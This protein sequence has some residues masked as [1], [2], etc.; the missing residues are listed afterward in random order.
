MLET[1]KLLFIG[2]VIG[3]TNVIPGVSGGTMAVVFN[4]YDRFVDVLTFN[5]QKLKANW[6]FVVPVLIG[7]AGGILFF[8]KVITILFVKFPNQTNLFFTGLILGSIPMLYLAA[9]KKY[10]TETTPTNKQPVI[11]TV[12]FIILGLALLL[13]IAYIQKKLNLSK[14]V[15]LETLPPFTLKLA[16]QLFFGGAVGAVAMIIPGVSGSFLMLIMGVYPIII[17]GISSIVMPSTFL[18]ALII[19]LP[20]GVG[21]LLGLACGARAISWLLKKFPNQTYGIILGLIGASI[22]LVF[23]GFSTWNSFVNILINI[24]CVVIGIAIA[25]FSSKNDKSAK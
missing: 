7:I 9:F 12:I 13:T 1:I 3:I 8:S 22:Y 20:N 16:I 19:L 18:Q 25:Y 11:S 5:I 2:L 15:M 4:I 10:N 24:L 23:P 6:K 17:K 14:N 21:T